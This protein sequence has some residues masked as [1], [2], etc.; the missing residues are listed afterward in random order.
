MC[1]S[2][3]GGAREAGEAQGR[4]LH[5]GPQQAPRR[6]RRQPLAVAP[7][8]GAPTGARAAAGPLHWLHHAGTPTT[9]RNSIL[10]QSN[11]QFWGFVSESKT[12]LLFDFYFFCYWFE[13]FWVK[14]SSFSIESCEYSCCFDPVWTYFELIGGKVYELNTMALSVYVAAWISCWYRVYNSWRSGGSFMPP[15]EMSISVI[16]GVIVAC[17]AFWFRS[18]RPWFVSA[19]WWFRR[20]VA[21][22][23]RTSTTVNR[24]FWGQR[25]CWPFHLAVPTCLLEVRER[26]RPMP[27]VPFPLRCL[28]L[29]GVPM[30]IHIISDDIVDFFRGW[31]QI[32]TSS[33]AAPLCLTISNSLSAAA[34]SA[35]ARSCSCSKEA[36]SLHACST[37]TVPSSAVAVLL[38]VTK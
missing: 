7:R 25:L 4:S 21:F 24:A 28:S 6:G 27:K 16:R 2:R 8:A 33:R 35:L 36:N 19:W 26:G 37:A 11:V 17:L 3:G 34:R 29:M 12:R 20:W 23:C 13:W 22:A 18:H 5:G 10:Y 9:L 15:S 31:K 1:D 32:R 30:N 38:R 14:K